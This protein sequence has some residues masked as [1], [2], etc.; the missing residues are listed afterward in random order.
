M[1]E[2]KLLRRKMLSWRRLILKCQLIRP[3]LMLL[4]GRE[5]LQLIV[6]W[7]I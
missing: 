4:W 7:S 1:R 2:S 5:T 3:K 6:S